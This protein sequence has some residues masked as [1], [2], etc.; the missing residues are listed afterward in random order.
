MLDGFDD[1]MK[2][3]ERATTTFDAASLD[4]ALEELRQWP[5]RLR[6]ADALALEQVRERLERYQYLCRFLD[7]TLEEALVDRE[8][9]EGYGRTHRASSEPPPVLME[10]Y[11]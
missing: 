9:G 6:G 7:Q 8:P 10:T 11:G 3:L 2:R 4:A 5:E 1:V